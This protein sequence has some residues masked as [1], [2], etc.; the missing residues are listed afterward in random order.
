MVYPVVMVSMEGVLCQALLDTGAGSSYASAALPTKLSRCTHEKEVWH[1]EMMLG[2]M[3]QEVELA[4]ITVWSTDGREELKVDVMMVEKGELLTLENPNHQALINSHA[5]LEGMQMED[6]VPKP[7][8]QINLILGARAYPAI[9][10]TQRPQVGQLSEPVVEKKKFRWKIMSP[11]RGIDHTKMR[12]THVTWIMSHELWRA[13]SPRHDGSARCPRTWP[14]RRVCG[15]LW[16][17]GTTTKRKAPNVLE[18]R[19]PTATKQQSREFA[20]LA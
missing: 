8:L 15:V 16:T 19:P 18:G 2:S 6:R 3:T 12:L 10:T 13:L 11:G 14:A 1:I 9:K 20:R 7:Y 17:T 5:H 4:T